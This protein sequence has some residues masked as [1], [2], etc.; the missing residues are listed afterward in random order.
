MPV[1]HVQVWEGQSRRRC[2]CV[3]VW[4]KDKFVPGLFLIPMRLPHRILPLASRSVREEYTYRAGYLDR[5]KGVY[6]VSVEVKT[7][8]AWS[9]RFILF[10]FFPRCHNSPVNKLRSLRASFWTKKTKGTIPKKY[11]LKTERFQIKSTRRR[12]RDWWWIPI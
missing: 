4:N 11:F 2:Q 1:S 5:H 12:T 8:R 6:G 3:K 7:Q 10:L 9:A